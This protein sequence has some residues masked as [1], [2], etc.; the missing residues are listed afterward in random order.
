MTLAGIIV[1]TAGLT[2]C[3]GTK[4]QSSFFSGK[5]LGITAH[6]SDIKDLKAECVIV[7]AAQKTKMIG[8]ISKK[9][10]NKNTTIKQKP[11]AEEIMERLARDH[12]H[13]FALSLK[14]KS[15]ARFYSVLS[16][17]WRNRDSLD[18]L[19]DAYRKVMDEGLDLTGLKNTK[20]VLAAESGV[21][22]NKKTLYIK[23]YYDV[24]SAVMSFQQAYLRE[25]G[26][27]KISDLI[28]GIRGKKSKKMDE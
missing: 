14:E 15:M 24:P 19:N 17:N 5:D 12:I 26:V 22:K 3:I 2:F 9:I 21:T 16:D 1:I 28:I 18:N 27:W 23:G 10:T 8:A 13:L 6:T 4:I 7:E 11:T 25:G 20:P